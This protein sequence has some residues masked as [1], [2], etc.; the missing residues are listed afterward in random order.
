MPISSEHWKDFE[1]LDSGDGMKLERW[2]EIVLSRPDPQALWQKGRPGAWS[3]AQG[4]YHRDE[5]GGG[6]WEFKKKP[7]E[8][9][10]LKYRDLAFKVRPTDF[11]HT[12]LF[13]EQA[14]NWDWMAEKVAEAKRP[15]QALNLFGYTGAAT[16]ALAKAG[17]S[18]AHVDA[19]KGMVQWCRENAA[20]NGLADA[21]IRY[22]VDDVSKF[23]DRELRR[24]NRYDA[25]VMDPPSYGRGK[26]GET[27]KLEKHLWPLMALCSKTLSKNPLFV[28]VNSYTTGLSPTVLANLVSDMVKGRVGQISSGELGLKQGSDGKMLPCGVFC[29]W[30]S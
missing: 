23:V 8:S 14:S 16:V 29:R 24:G 19:A 28:L 6:H 30:E 18:V 13:P 22:L 1:L 21:P 11:K 7:P 25:V 26:S 3:S 17:A 10:T 12:G 20:L 27:W 4:V 5:K 9:W 15:I 2:G